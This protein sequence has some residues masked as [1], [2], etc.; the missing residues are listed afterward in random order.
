[1]SH[2]KPLPKQFTADLA[3]GSATA[4]GQR[5]GWLI[6]NAPISN[7]VKESL[8]TLLPQM[9]PEQID[10]LSDL[11]LSEFLNNQTRGIDD[12]FKRELE[13]IKIQADKEEEKIIASA[14]EDLGKLEQKLKQLSTKR[15]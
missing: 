13:K 14:N 5:L 2:A 6:A 4:L 1:M 12:K 11:L 7:D 10:R 3:R 8:L 15:T 9:T